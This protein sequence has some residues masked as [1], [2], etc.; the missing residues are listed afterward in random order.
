ME[1]TIIQAVLIGFVCWLGSIENPQPL[2]LAL[3]DMLARPLVGG[4][5]VGLIL[6]DLTTGVII[7]AAIQTMY[8][9]NVVAG[10]VAAADMSFV[11]YPSIALAMIAGADTTVAI[12]IATTVG[13]LGAALFTAYET[14]MSVF[15]AAADRRLE[16]GNI[17]GMRRIYIFGP[18]ITSFIMRFGITFVTVLLGVSF[19][20]DILDSIPALMLHIMSVLGGV[21][22]AVGIAILLSNSVND[23]KMFAF[24]FIGIVMASYGMNMVTIAVV[25]GCLAV[26]FY[27]LYNSSGSNNSGGPN[28]NI[29]IS[30]EEA[31]L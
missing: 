25:A 8:L 21:L 26:I 13:I 1:V 22:P 23:G 6:G 17:E 9:S 5:L 24:F 7:G 16:K 31:V 15:T 29:E 2:G 14:F 27:M 18:M 28:N 12:T 19:A 3:S 11:S 30:D 20:Q 4:T 10:G